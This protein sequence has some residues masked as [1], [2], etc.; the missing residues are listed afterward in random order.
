MV[1]GELVRYISE[2]LT[3]EYGSAV[4]SE[5]FQKGSSDVHIRVFE[6][7][8]DLLIGFSICL[9]WRRIR[10][11][12]SP[13][14]VITNSHVYQQWIRNV[15]ENRGAF[16]FFVEKLN[17]LQVQ[18]HYQ[19]N[20]ESFDL[21]PNV[22]DC[23]F[24]SVD[25]VSSYLEVRDNL[26]FYPEN[27]LPVLKYFWGLILS[28]TGVFELEELP[29]EGR[30]HTIQTSKYERNYVYRKLCIEHYGCF[31]Q[32]CGEDLS[33]KYGDAALG[34]IEVHHI[35]P[36]SEYEAPKVISP[37]LDLLPVCPNCHAI[38]HRRKPAFLPEEVKAMLKKEGRND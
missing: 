14:Y 8:S 7:Q 25:A 30:M 9:S 33:K 22:D 38:L 36:V 31:C 20:Q 19:I 16:D 17:Q 26:E 3:N 32:I 10:I 23:A 35:E 21:C 28:F 18:L 29:E 34:F 15:K 37:I 24:F 27:I 2:Q 13:R 6:K 5:L 1:I 4:F 11:S 12:F